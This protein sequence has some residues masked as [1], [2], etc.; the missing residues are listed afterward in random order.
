MTVWNPY[1]RFSVKKYCEF[2]TRLVNARGSLDISVCSSS[3][4]DN[5]SPQACVFLRLDIASVTSCLSCFATNRNLYDH[6]LVLPSVFSVRNYGHKQDKGRRSAN[7]L[8]FRDSRVS[9]GRI[10]LPQER[11]LG[12]L[13]RGGSSEK[14][15][16]DQMPYAAATAITTTPI[17]TG[18]GML[19]WLEE[20]NRAYSM[21]SVSAGC[22]ENGLMEWNLTC[23]KSCSNVQF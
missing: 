21:E 9:F 7:L 13:G 17:L 2:E 11:H 22:F 10:V 23:A 8:A 6:P 16:R 4:I 15:R 12:Y 20:N 1:E 3:L 14:G 18:S 19:F 5:H